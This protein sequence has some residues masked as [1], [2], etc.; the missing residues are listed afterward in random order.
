MRAM[1]DVALFLIACAGP[2]LAQAQDKL[3]AKQVEA[4]MEKNACTACHQLDAKV[5]GPSWKEVAA[6][7]KDDKTASDKVAERV[8]KGSSGIWGA[9]PMPANAGVTDAEAKGLV[10]W[11][12]AQ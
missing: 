11:I 1:R 6:K 9:V 3:D 5:L 2:S 4:L 10:T 12:F 8:K 7:Y